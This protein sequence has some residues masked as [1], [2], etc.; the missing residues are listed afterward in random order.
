MELFTTK[1]R[2]HSFVDRDCL[3]NLTFPN[4]IIIWFAF[5]NRDARYGGG[6]RLEMLA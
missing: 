6:Q 1:E 5:N 2:Y 3:S 4:N